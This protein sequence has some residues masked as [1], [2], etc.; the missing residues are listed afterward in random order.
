MVAGMLEGTTNTTDRRDV[1]AHAFFSDAAAHT[2]SLERDFDFTEVSYAHIKHPPPHTHTH[3]HTHTHHP[4][5]LNCA[6]TV[7]SDVLCIPAP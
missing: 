4:Y 5:Y 2:T 1:H 3:T 6:E 7:I